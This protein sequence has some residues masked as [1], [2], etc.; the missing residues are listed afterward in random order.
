MKRVNTEAKASCGCCCH[1]MGSKEQ[2]RVRRKYRPRRKIIPGAYW[3][4]PEEWDQGWVIYGDDSWPSW[5]CMLIL[6]DLDQP[7]G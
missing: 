4:G 3:R 6:P 1:V 5:S 2:P 7:G